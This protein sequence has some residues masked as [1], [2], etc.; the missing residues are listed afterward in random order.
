MLT[1]TKSAIGQASN[2]KNARLYAYDDMNENLMYYHECKKL[3]DYNI[4]YVIIERHNNNMWV[5]KY[6]IKIIYEIDINL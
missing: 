6:V 5:E 2:I 1:I 3:I 4:T